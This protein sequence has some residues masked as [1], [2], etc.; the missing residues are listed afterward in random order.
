MQI[1]VLDGYIENPGDL[2]WDGL[3]A[4]GELVVYD[5]TSLTDENEIIGRI[6]SAQ[7]VITNKTPITARIMDDCPN[8]GFIAVL[9]T[10]YNVV[11]CAEAARRGIPVSNVPTYGTQ[12]VAQFAMALLLE[13]C[14]HVGLHDQSVH[15]GEWE[16]CPNFCY[17]KKPVI[18]LAGKTMGIIGFGRIGQAMGR[19]ARAIG[20][21][22]LATG[23][24]PTAEGEAIARYVDLDTVL[25]SADVISLHCPLTAE[26][27]RLINRNTISKMRDGVILINTA[28]GGLIHEADAAQALNTGKLGALAVDVVSVEPITGDNPLLE[29]KNC[30]ITP[31]IAWSGRDC[32]R[33]IMDCTVENVRAYL[34]GQ[35]KNVVNG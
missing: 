7:V 26:T 20:M 10:G 11:D 14:C 19:I 18:E 3:R 27:N 2:S 33:R 4:L 16:S 28:R 1:V 29:A 23:S 9:A 8:M 22:V 17:W 21:E 35:P 31:H 12:A 30:V 5:R 24:R 13:V 32:R 25:K 34:A 6:G 15:A